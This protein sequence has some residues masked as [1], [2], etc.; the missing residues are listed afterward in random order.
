MRRLGR[1][2]LF[3]ALTCML[4]VGLAV[5]GEAQAQS[6]AAKIDLNTATQAELEKLPGV[7]EVTAKKII[8]GRPYKTVADLEKAGVNKA[9]IDKIRPLVTASAT[10]QAGAAKAPAQAT[11]ID[12]AKV[13]LNTASQAELEK[14]PGVGEATAK[15]IIDGRP[16]K[17]VADLQKA[18]VN[19]ATIEKITP[20]VSVGPA[21]ATSPKPAAKTD[22]TKPTTTA[23]S[24]DTTVVAK[25]PPQKG[26][27]WVNTDSGIYHREGDRWYGKT[28][29]GEFMTEAEA[30][31]KGY[32]EA[33]K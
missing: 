23:K 30:Q 4:V 5:F 3:V 1:S 26:M 20:L 9:T 22:T 27:V 10:G 16:Y 33:K 15:K 8:D 17:S 32:R 19:K 12:T 14:L 29:Q 13:D 24:S 7:G 2:P 18:G 31:K 21:A 28:K 6:K 25:T 11:T